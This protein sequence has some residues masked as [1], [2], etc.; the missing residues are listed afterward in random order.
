MSTLLIGDSILRHIP[1]HP[2]FVVH[3]FPGID[4]QSLLEK[5]CEGALD[6]C[7]KGVSFIIILVGTNDVPFCFP[8]KVAQKI[9]SVG[10]VF[11]CRK[12][13]IQ[14]A[15]A[16]VLP[17]P[18]DGALYDDATRRTNA[19]LPSL[20]DRAGLTLLPAFRPFLRNNR[21]NPEYFVPD[22]LHLNSKGLTA[23]RRGFL[24][25]IDR[26]VRRG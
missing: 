12:R 14:V 10:C 2:K 9:V 20:C 8:H 3:F 26:H 1:R 11:K 6:D 5:V 13:N 7:L 24:S 15:I 17:R 25:A 19:I 21:P 4:C 18:A 23:L 16:G 22:G